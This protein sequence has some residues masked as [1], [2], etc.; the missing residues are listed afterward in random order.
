MKGFKKCYICNAVDGTD[1]SM[2]WNVSAEDGNVRSV[3]KMKTLTVKMET[4]TMTGISR[5]N[6]TSFV[7]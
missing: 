5:Q 4:V 3:R 6:L 1:D 7:Q 2:L